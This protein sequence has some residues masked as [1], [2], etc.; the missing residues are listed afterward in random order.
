[1]RP[2]NDGARPTSSA[3]HAGATANFKLTF[4]LDHSAGA[5]HHLNN[6]L[7]RQPSKTVFASRERK[8]DRLARGN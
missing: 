5:D 7:K 2:R 8:V 3:G 6:L 1:M 4:Y